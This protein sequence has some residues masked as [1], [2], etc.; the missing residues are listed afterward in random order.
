MPTPRLPET[1]NPFGGPATKAPTATPLLL[2]TYNL[3]RPSTCTLNGSSPAS[4]FTCSRAF[5]VLAFIPILPILVIRI[6]EVSSVR[7]IKSTA[8][9][10][11]IKFD[12]GDVPAFPVSDQALVLPL[13]SLL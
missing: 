5:I 1:N 9:V 8:S 12:N 4:P 3:V 11:P 7:K 10:V 2:D 13:F 6:R